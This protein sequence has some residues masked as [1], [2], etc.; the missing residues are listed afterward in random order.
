MTSRVARTTRAR[1][2]LRKT[3]ALALGLFLVIG[4]PGV[5]S[6]SW[7]TSSLP[8]SAT[9]TAASS[10]LTQSG[11]SNLTFTYRSNARVDTALVTITNPGSVA[12]PYTHT[13]IAPTATT[14]SGN[15]TIIAWTVTSS[16]NCSPQVGSPGTS[17][18]SKTFTTGSVQSG[19][20]AAGQ[21]RLVCIRTNVT[22]AGVTASAG[23]STQ[24]ESRVETS[25][26]GWPS[27]DFATQNVP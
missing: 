16:A 23:S 6:A 27:I 19:T 10:T 18:P 4:L 12:V 5:A 2:S 26:G 15:T 11:F 20:L 3:L 21:Q 22:S 14:L 24:A 1:P 7:I 9:V 8:S 13:I 25:G 17:G